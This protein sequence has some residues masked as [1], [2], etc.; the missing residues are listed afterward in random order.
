MKREIEP[1]KKNLESEDLTQGSG[2]E[3][4]WDGSEGEI[5][6]SEMCSSNKSVLI[7]GQGSRG[8]RT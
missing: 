1:R 3:N 6:G 7:G 8:L 2:K 4:P 5:K